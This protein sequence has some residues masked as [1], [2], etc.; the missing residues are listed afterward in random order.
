MQVSFAGIAVCG[1]LLILG[2]F[3]RAP[4]LVALI[5]SFAFGSTAIGTID[6]L[7]GSSPLV[8]TVFAMLL[9]AGS[10]LRRHSFSQIWTVLSQSRVPWILLCLILYAMAGAYILPRLFAGRTSAFVPSRDGGEVFELPLE[11][12]S[13]NITQTAYLALGALTFLALSALLV[14]QDNLQAVRR[15]FFIFCTLHVALG[16]IDLFGKLLGA[17]DILMMIRS[18]SYALATNSEEAGFYRIAGG[19]PEAS[20]FGGFT[21]ACLAFTSTY[22]RRSRSRLALVLS[23][24]LVILL[25][26]STSTT[27]YVGAVFIAAPFAWS[28]VKNALSG[29]IRREDVVL[30]TFII[31]AIMMILAIHAYDAEIFRPFVELFDATIFNKSNSFSVEERGLWNTQSLR[32]FV[33]TIGLGMGLGS[34]RAS[35]WPVAVISQ[36]GLVGT[37]LI[38]AIVVETMKTLGPLQSAASASEIAFHDGVRAFALLLL[39]AATLSGGGADPGTLFFIALAT[40]VACRAQLSRTASHDTA[41][42]QILARR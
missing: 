36:L 40:V 1:G 37:L 25:V 32:S 15:G 17:G 34:S 28:V 5:A 35:S 41:T 38:A 24:A 12:V 4:I 7:G 2:Y 30:S 31:A 19:Y 21:L 9:I 16:F 11:P 29:R 20:A 10:V 13:G 39:V 42:A 14:R 3:A 8:F 33:D 18:A 26:L 27:A 6:P 23:I 22:W